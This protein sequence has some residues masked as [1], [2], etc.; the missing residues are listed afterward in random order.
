VSS[1]IAQLESEIKML[2]SQIQSIFSS[3]GIN[4]PGGNPPPSDSSTGTAV[5]ADN[6]AVSPDGLV[7]FTGNGFGPNE[8]VNISV[9]GTVIG[10]AHTDSNGTLSIGGTAANTPGDTTY[11]FQGTNSGDSDSVMIT[12][13]T[14]Q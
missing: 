14:D 10:Q 7:H 5:Y 6:Y 8:I 4:I 1:Q 13:V 11:W 3:G 2:E 12:V 9:D